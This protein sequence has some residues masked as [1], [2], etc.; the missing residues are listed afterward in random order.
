MYAEYAEPVDI[1]PI[2]LTGVMWF[3]HFIWELTLIIFYIELYAQFEY[4]L[5]LLPN[6][7][8]EIAALGLFQSFGIEPLCKNGT[9]WSPA[10]ARFDFN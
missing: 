1:C 3:F 6:T 10:A 2:F 5:N 8:F 9:D 7:Y 4:L